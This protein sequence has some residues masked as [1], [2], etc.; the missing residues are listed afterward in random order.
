MGTFMS[1]L[2][3]IN[4][5]LI[6]HKL[7]I[8]RN[9]E[10]S[11]PNFRKLLY[12]LTLLMG[13]ELTRDLTVTYETIQ[14]PLTAMQAPFVMGEEMAIV[15]ILRAGLGMS[16]ALLELIPTACIGHI[17]VY[18]D[19]KT[20]SPIE[21][22]V[23][24]P[25]AKNRLFLLVDPMIATGYSS[26]YS[27]DVLLKHGVK[28]GNIRFLALVCAPEGVKVFHDHHPEVPL[29]TAAL[30]EKLNEKAYIVPGLGDAGDRIFGTL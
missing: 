9:K 4:H 28:I 1:N 16:E 21:Y 12:E 18:R 13:Y 26:A 3:V 25:E 29:Y 10:T 23:R 6:Q 2:H 17:G 19:P 8:M 5:P 20:K 24:L 22:M 14:T 30:D 15:P 7:S 27:V 11:S